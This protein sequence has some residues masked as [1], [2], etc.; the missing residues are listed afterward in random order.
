MKFPMTG[1]EKG[2][3]LTEVATS[4][5]LEKLSAVFVETGDHYRICKQRIG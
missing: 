3:P 4:A 5:G 2:D 1:Q